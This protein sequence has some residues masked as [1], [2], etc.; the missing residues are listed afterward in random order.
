M[1]VEHFLEELAAAIERS[2]E[3]ERGQL[4]ERLRLAQEFVGTADALDFLR[5]WKVPIE[6]YQPIYPSEE[7]SE[8]T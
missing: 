6:I 3:P 1:A 7:S 8:T 5:G 2:S 4:M